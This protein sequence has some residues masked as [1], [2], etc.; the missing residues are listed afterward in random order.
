MARAWL[1]AVWLVL[2]T[3]APALPGFL[4][5]TDAL[6]GVSACCDAGCCCDDGAPCE[7]GSGA[8]PA[9]TSGCSCGHRDDGAIRANA[10]VCAPAPASVRLSFEAPHSTLAALPARV[11]A[12]LRPCPDPPP[13]RRA[14]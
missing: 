7:H 3:V 12:G 1:A 6:D 5:A 13:P 4:V 9:L 10:P 14:G 8:G 2:L 11:A